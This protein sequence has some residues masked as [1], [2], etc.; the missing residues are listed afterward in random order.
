MVAL[1]LIGARCTFLSVASAREV[2]GPASMIV[3]VQ[4]PA[5]KPDVQC[6]GEC[7][8]PRRA[9][10]FAPSTRWIR[11]GIFAGYPAFESQFNERIDSGP[12]S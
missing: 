10:P 5:S 3:A 6:G 12:M 2:V 4:M 9:H 7:I 11:C 1:R 8:H